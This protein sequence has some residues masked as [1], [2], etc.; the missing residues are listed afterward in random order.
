MPKL[1][2]GTSKVKKGPT[3][4]KAVVIDF[5]SEAK[6]LASVDWDSESWLE[7][8]L[9][10][11]G[12]GE[13]YQ[14]GPKA[15]RHFSNA[16]LSFRLSS[17]LSPSFDSLFNAGRVLFLLATDHLP[18]PLP[19]LRDSITSYR[20]ALAFEQGRPR[21]SPA[22]VIDAQFNLAAAFVAM[23]ELILEGAADGTMGGEESPTAVQC[24]QEAR[25]LFADVERIQRIEME[26]VFSG[27][28][29]TDQ[30]EEGAMREVEGEEE[31]GATTTVTPS[32]IIDTLLESVSNDLFLF[33]LLPDPSSLLSSLLAAL[34][35]PTSLRLLIPPSHPNPDQDLSITLTHLS[36]ATTC[37]PSLPSSSPYALPPSSILSQYE[38]LALSN[39]TPQ[40]Q[41]ELADYLLDSFSL[42]A[43]P[44]SQLQASENAYLAAYAIL[45]NRLA[46]PRS[47]PAHVLPSLLSAN[48]ASR[49]SIY[50]LLHHHHLS[51][52]PEL[53]TSSL[54]TAT[55]LAIESI[56]IA[57]SGI[58]ISVVSGSQIKLT[59]AGPG[60]RR[61]WRTIRTTRDALLG[62]VRIRLRTVG[63]A[64][65][66]GLDLVGQALGRAG[67]KDV[68]R[69]VEDVRGDAAW[70]AAG[71]GVEQR[72]WD[73]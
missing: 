56:E 2:R 60:A 27:G 62:L 26:K 65:E 39:P 72:W 3:K 41:S 38:S 52:S 20:A 53:A 19:S 61:D 6:A 37:G 46:P 4:A 48:L 47:I 18:D 68:E 50:L 35:R 31:S 71:E 25:T 64:K 8:G 63:S 70:V 69:F 13:R 1:P 36:L 67:A 59:P 54:S 66:A 10:Q 22:D 5:S 34:D 73:A 42:A 57:G 29:Q 14:H 21:P 49:A 55:Q 33:P 16:A 45:Q 44:L 43:S 32:L 58:R 15:A 51:S 30:E 23:A 24:A 7:E 12:N 40:L 28:I 17:S 11:E 9:R